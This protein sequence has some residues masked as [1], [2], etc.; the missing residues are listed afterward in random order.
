M[1]VLL[2]LGIAGYLWLML[3]AGSPRWL[4]GA[5]GAAVWVLVLWFF[6]TGL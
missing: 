4:R 3:P 5:A 2:A 1:K 6:F